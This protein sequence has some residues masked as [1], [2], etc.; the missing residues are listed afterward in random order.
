MLS[1]HPNDEAHCNRKQTLV[2]RHRKTKSSPTDDEPLKACRD[3]EDD[4]Y[5]L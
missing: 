4:R 5:Y 1:K 3:E 2:N